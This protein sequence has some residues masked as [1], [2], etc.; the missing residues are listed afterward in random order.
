M[1]R[2]AHQKQFSNL[3]QKK[4]HMQI[5]VLKNHGQIWISPQVSHPSHVMCL[6]LLQLSFL[7]VRFINFFSC[8]I[9]ILLIVILSA[10]LI[11]KHNWIINMP[12]IFFNVESFFNFSWCI[13][14]NAIWD[15]IRLQREDYLTTHYNLPS[16]YWYLM[17]C[18]RIH[19][20][21]YF[22]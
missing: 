19:D 3:E 7:F 21:H 11:I 5:S 9:F 13:V 20:K 4:L 18:Y 15:T 1:G 6:L 16:H 8:I 2:S 17:S 12:K 22:M 10:S 14:N